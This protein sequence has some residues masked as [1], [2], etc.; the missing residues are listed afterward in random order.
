MVILTI[1]FYIVLFWLTRQHPHT[2]LLAVFF[3]FLEV[4][5]ITAISVFFSTFSSPILSSVFTF[6]FFVIGRLAPD[7]QLL[8]TK[9]KAPITQ[10]MLSAVYYTIPNLDNFNIQGRILYAEPVSGSHILFAVSYALIYTIILIAVACHVFS[11][12]DL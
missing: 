9:V 6:F 5:V 4:M 10:F 3:S 7:I 11:R 12:R 2:L 8:A 1:W